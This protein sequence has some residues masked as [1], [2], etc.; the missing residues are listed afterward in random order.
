[1]SLS[2]NILL[3]AF[4]RPRGLLGRL[5]GIIMA[6]T[7]DRHAAWTIGLL[8]VQPTDKVREV[9]F[10]PGIAIQRLSVSTR[11]V[12]GVDPSAEMLRQATRRNTAA[13][14]DRRVDLR[15]TSADRLPFT[16]RR[17]DKAL[18]INSMQ[19]WPDAL[20]G[21]REIRCVLKPGG[22]LALTFTSY[23]GQSREGVPELVAAAEFGEC[24][25]VDA[26]KAF[27]VFARP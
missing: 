14:A 16:E 13:I 22:G 10:G 26:D 3:R 21:L 7:N 18:A 27:C 1:M 2:R 17:F 4:G 20:A 15:Q 9:G 19:V 24:R 8:D 6:R 5:G 12:C 25:V 11:Q 23:S